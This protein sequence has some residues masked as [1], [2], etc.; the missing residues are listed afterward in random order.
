MAEPPGNGTVLVSALSCPSASFCV[1]VGGSTGAAAGRYT[2]FAERWNG[3]GWSVEA[4]P[5]PARPALSSRLTSVS[6]TSPIACTA[7]GESV[8]RNPRRPPTP[9]VERWNGTTW[10]LE[11]A[12]GGPLFSVS[13]STRR[14]CTAVSDVAGRRFAEGWDGSTWSPQPNPHPR[15]F[16]A[17]NGDDELGSVSCASRSACM[18][19]G[20]STWGTG[21]NVVRIT[22]AEY[23][24]GT[25][26]SVRRT[27]N[28]I[29]LDDLKGVSCY[30]AHSCVAVGDY[31]DRGGDA[32]VSLVERWHGGRWSVLPTPRR[33]S[34][35]KRSDSALQAVTCFAKGGCIAVGDAQGGPFAAEFSSQVN[36]S[37]K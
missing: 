11:H 33:L 15:A 30:S 9:L 2:P 29:Q 28:P 6:C 14:T 12:S 19:V 37:A 21:F 3:A 27:P 34:A 24:N 32:T 26:W 17:P 16:P 8:S 35:G 13:C 1:A 5:G 22:L 31:T 4:V 18:A 23:W 20:Y 25:S 36:G 10:S 7:V